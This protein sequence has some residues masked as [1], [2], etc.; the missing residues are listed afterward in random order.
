MLKTF[1]I[2]VSLFLMVNPSFACG[3]LFNRK[4]KAVDRQLKIEAFKAEQA[5]I[6]SL[7][8]IIK[9]DIKFQQ[10]LIKDLIKK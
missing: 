3:G 2:T 5:R 6:D 10:D 4:D 9:E 7:V 8:Q 1:I